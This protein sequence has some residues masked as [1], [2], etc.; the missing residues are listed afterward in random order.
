[1]NKKIL[2]TRANGEQISGQFD[3]ITFYANSGEG[4]WLFL[5]NCTNG[6]KQQGFDLQYVQAV[7]TDDGKDERA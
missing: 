6:F 1:M 5:K 7:T 2:V 3:G 4:V